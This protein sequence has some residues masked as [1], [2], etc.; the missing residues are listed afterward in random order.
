[1][2][3]LDKLLFLVL[4]FVI[5]WIVAQVAGV[6]GFL[7]CILIGSDLKVQQIE[8][9]CTQRNKSV[10]LS[11][12]QFYKSKEEPPVYDIV[13]YKIRTPGDGSANIWKTINLKS[14][15]I[16]RRSEDVERR[17]SSRKR[18]EHCIRDVR[19]TGWSL[20]VASLFVMEHNA[21][22][23]P[24]NAANWYG[25][26]GKK[27][28][29]IGHLGWVDSGIDLARKENRNCRESGVCKQMVSMGKTAVH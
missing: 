23:C 29:Y 25:F 7:G 4:N 13:G 2:T 18:W 19:N 10:A 16:Q 1:M 5:S 11:N 3:L 17:S 14:E 8:L 22:G 9:D 28:G 12:P 27:L 15:N 26:A 24:K 6:L 21:V 20:V